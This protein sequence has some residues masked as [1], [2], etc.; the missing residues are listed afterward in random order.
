MVVR[1]EEY[2]WSSYRARIGLIQCDWLDAD[3]CF[4]GLGETD[5]QRRSRYK[6]FVEEGV[7]K[8]QLKFIRDAIQRNQLTGGEAFIMEIE[9]RTGERVLFRSR[10]GPRSTL[11]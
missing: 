1:P 11:E 6:K 4:L 10:G 2:E 7:C 8:Y 5:G 3:P 9:Q